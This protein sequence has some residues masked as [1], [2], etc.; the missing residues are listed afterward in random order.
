MVVSRPPCFVLRPFVRLLWTSEPDACADLRAAAGREHVLPTG[1]M[2]L[3][4]RL[5]GPAVRLFGDADD[6]QG[7]LLGQ[8]VIGG[9]RSSHYAREVAPACTVGAQLEPG[10][11][12]ALFGAP[13]DVFSHRH[14]GLADVWGRL[15]GEWTEQLEAAATPQARLALF[16]RLLWQRL[17]NAR[18][19]HP[20]ALQALSFL[21]A[22][23][24]VEQVVHAVGC[25]HRHL[26]NVFRHATGLAPKE[27]SRILRLQSVLQSMHRD[28]G[29]AWADAALAAG[30]SDQSHFNREF[31]AFSGLTPST[32][33]RA[34]PSHPNH[35]PLPAR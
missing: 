20:A 23:R 31:R 12:A 1:H 10:A 7:T 18:A 6:E 15:A 19:L 21:Q 17:R 16:E 34:Q 33:Q 3:A 24:T 2:H 4:L 29:L 5:R 13:A 14:T 27:Y 25:S 11:A 9:A 28:T 32:W 26:I 22:G 30:Y 35:V 8:A